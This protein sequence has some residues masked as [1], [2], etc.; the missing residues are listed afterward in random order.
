MELKERIE[1]AVKEIVADILEVSRTT[2][3]TCEDVYRKAT[4]YA[5]AFESPEFR[6][7]KANLGIG[8]HASQLEAIAEKARTGILP[9]GWEGAE[10]EVIIAQNQKGCNVILPA[11]YFCESLENDLITHAS[12]AVRKCTGEDDVS[13]G[14]V[15]TGNKLASIRAKEGVNIRQLESEIARTP[16]AM[17]LAGIK[18]TTCTICL[19]ELCTYTP[20]VPLTVTA[21]WLDKGLICLTKHARAILPPYKK[22]FTIFGHGFEHF[23]AAVTSECAD[24]QNPVGKYICS[25]GTGELK[26][27]LT[28]LRLS[29]GDRIKLVSN[30][31]K[32]PASKYL[33]R[34]I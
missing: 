5:R 11:A 17:A 3:I 31:A 24:V 7:V 18:I 21:S 33:L 30:N 23:E 15:D 2:A 26:R 6:T 19:P 14:F 10:I 1:G 16:Y 27:A 12:E 28:A 34:K 32:T 22:N 13:F 29:V 25:R 20:Q 8:R 4:G 9:K